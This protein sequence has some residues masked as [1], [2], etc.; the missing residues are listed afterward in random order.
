LLHPGFLID[1][2]F[3]PEDGDMF[4]RNVNLLSTEYTALYPRKQNFKKLTDQPNNWLITEQMSD[5]LKQE[6]PNGS[7]AEN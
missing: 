7:Q 2:F 3:D 1:L 6:Q 4:L 5:C